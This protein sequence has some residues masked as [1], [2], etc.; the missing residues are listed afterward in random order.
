[1]RPAPHTHRGARWRPVLM[2]VIGLLALAGGAAAAG[3][4][5][6]TSTPAL[7]PA[8]GPAAG[9]H[10][11]LTS[12]SGSPGVPAF[13]DGHPVAHAA[14]TW[15]PDDPGNT[16]TSGG[17]QKLQWN[18]S[19]TDGVNAPQAWANLRADGKPGGK[20]VI[21][22]VLDTGVAFRNWDDFERSPDF[23]GTRFVDPCDLVAGKIVDGKC[24]DPYPLD[25]NGHG[26][27]VAGAIAE[28]T[29]NGVGVTGLAYGV[30]I[31]P[32]RV[33]N[34]NAWG[35]PS[36]IAAGI[37]YAVQNGAQV[38][39]LSLEF[40][41][42]LN[43][44]EIPSVISAIRYANQHNVVVVAAAGNDASD[45]IAYP[46]RDNQTISVGATTK[47]GCMAEYSDSSSSLDLVAPGGGDDAPLSEPQCHPN[48][49]L[50][51]VYQMT[52]ANPDK[53]DDFSL[54][55]GWIGT[56]IASPD[57]SAAAAL[58]IASGVLGP[59]PSP[60][61]ILARLEQTA[62]PIGTTVPNANYG[63]GLLNA[64]AATSKLVPVKPP[65]PIT[66]TT[67]VTTP[68]T[69]TTPPVAGPSQ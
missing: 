62:T 59:H 53:P 69:T 12:T 37:R 35:Y 4:T 1:M 46:A 33:L 5:S 51:D 34:A 43:P 2:T 41:L 49:R 6:P 58:V 47:D 28:A 19:A 65:T 61:Q 42:G 20:G 68:T 31:M 30:S 55:G 50:S 24:T 40:Y 23:A 64:G 8:R 38:I 18:F 22:A 27:W 54:P 66:P 16:D 60:T 15:I 67:T 17:W 25:R 14:G 36:T 26:T 10:P 48:R 3:A 56:S 29:N 63:W 9:T 32:V 57:V 21:V 44:D 11:S 52:F 39:N 7:S 45:Q 13:V